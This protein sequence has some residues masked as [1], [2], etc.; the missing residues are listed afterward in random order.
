LEETNEGPHLKDDPTF[1]LL[2]SIS[3][4]I[5]TMFNETNNLLGLDAI[6]NG[7][8]IGLGNCAS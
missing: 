6:L 1:A 2:T 8:L 3:L 4:H 5:V 7:E